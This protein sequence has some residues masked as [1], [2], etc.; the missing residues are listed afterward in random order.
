MLQIARI[1]KGRRLESDG[2]NDINVERESIS[3]LSSPQPHC[4]PIHLMCNADDINK[5]LTAISLLPAWWVPKK[6]KG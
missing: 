3:A 2:V 1:D 4:L 6:R 5:S